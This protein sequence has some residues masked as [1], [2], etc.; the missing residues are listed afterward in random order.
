MKPLQVRDYSYSE[1]EQGIDEWI[2][3][4]RNSKRDR[5]ILK[6]K[7]LDGLSY[8]E[9]AEILDNDDTLPPSYKLSVRQLERIVPKAEMIL[10]K[11]I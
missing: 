11:H 10:F 9:I 2:V 8:L 5:F 7:L 1:I 4:R 6:L 3:G